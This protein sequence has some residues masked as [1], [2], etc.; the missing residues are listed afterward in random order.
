MN[1]YA[2]AVIDALNREGYSNSEWG[3]VDG[4]KDTNAYFGTV[5]SFE[6]FHQYAYVYADDMFILQSSRSKQKL[7]PEH[8]LELE[9]SDQML[10]L[11]RLD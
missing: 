9:D 1:D 3:L 5:D 10:Y 7:N 2:F 11:Y 4:V 6:L 8:E